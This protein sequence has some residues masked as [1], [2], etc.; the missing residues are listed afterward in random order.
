MEPKI[1]HGELFWE[2]AWIFVQNWR[3]GNK[4]RQIKYQGCPSLLSD[5]CPILQYTALYGR[6][7][8]QHSCVE[9]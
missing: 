3:R 6:S 2:R 5:A 9:R 8:A 7:D 1:T 4:H